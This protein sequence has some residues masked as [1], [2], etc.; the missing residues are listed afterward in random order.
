M[1][2]IDEKFY[3]RL[4]TRALTKKHEDLLRDVLPQFS[5]QS[6][7]EVEQKKYDAVFLEIGFGDGEH[8]AKLALQNP[9]ALF[10]GA[11]PFVNG[12][13][14]L[15]T[16]IEK[17]CIQNVRIFHDDVRKLLKLL[18]DCMFDGVF[19]LFPD[20]WP[21]RRHHSRRFVQEHSIFSIHR[22]LKTNGF[23]NIATDHAD[24]ASWILKM[25][26][27]G[28]I[29]NMFAK[30]VFNRESRPS[31]ETWPKTKYEQKAASFD[32][33]FAKYVKL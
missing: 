6:F 1:Q 33:L 11:E 4:K 16:K 28:E 9:E 21:K 8:M 29:G 13:A 2:A 27:S 15:L 32:I 26:D 17:Y 24:Y 3:G 10:I 22:I 20:P 18:P 12:V 14:A 23:W 5:F 7:S 19:L 25:F 30:S 31:E